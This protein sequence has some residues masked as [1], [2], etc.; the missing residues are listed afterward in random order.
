MLTILTLSA[1]AKSVLL[2][3]VL[4]VLASTLVKHNAD[5][6]NKSDM[7]PGNMTCIEACSTALPTLVICLPRPSM[8]DKLIVHQASRGCCCNASLPKLATARSVGWQAIKLQSS[9]WYQQTSLS[10]LMGL[11]LHCLQCTCSYKQTTVGIHMQII[12]LT[13]NV[14][15]HVLLCK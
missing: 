13:G 9:H 11:W 7:W 12:R 14:L 3:F 8:Q 2:C 10:V 1:R 15:T 6:R 4:T 5:V